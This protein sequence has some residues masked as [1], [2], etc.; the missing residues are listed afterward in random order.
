MVGGFCQDAAKKEGG[1]WQFLVL[2]KTYR[3]NLGKFDKFGP[4]V[5]SEQIVLSIGL[6]GNKTPKFAVVVPIK[7]CPKAVARNRTKRLIWENL[8]QLKE[9][10]RPGNYKILVW[11]D[12]SKLGKT[13]V[14][15]KLEGI[16]AKA[17]V[18]ND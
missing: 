3:L 8:A 13:Q 6:D 16:F 4:K 10:I 17:Q 14:G 5:R 18:F 12:F 7:F 2:K 15:K 9:R 11:G 1:G